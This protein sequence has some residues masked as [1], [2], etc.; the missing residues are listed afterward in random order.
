MHARLA[1]ANR[2]SL[3]R[4]DHVKADTG[5]RW[6]GIVN[7]P[8]STLGDAVGYGLHPVIKFADQGRSTR[9]VQTDDSRPRRL[10]HKSNKGLLQPLEPA[11][12]L[13]VIGFDVCDD[14]RLGVKFDERPVTFISFDHQIVTATNA[15]T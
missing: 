11:V 7:T 6:D 12:V 5:R 3:I 2:S 10:S 14:D 8:D 1:K 4:S 13:Q 15:G 9:V